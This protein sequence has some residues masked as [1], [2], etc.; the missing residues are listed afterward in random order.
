V[1]RGN[2]QLPYIIAAVGGGVLFISLFL[3]WVSGPSLPAGAAG[4]LGL[5]KTGWELFSAVDVFL[6]ILG[7][8]TIAYCVL[9]V[10]GIEQWPWLRAF[11]RWG[12]LVGLVIV[13][14]YVVDQ[15]NAPTVSSFSSDLG[16]GVYVA[17]VASLAIFL[18]GLLLVRPDLARRLE[19]ATEGRERARPDATSAQP[20]GT[21]AATATPR[22][23]AP[24]A[25]AVP[26]ARPQAPAAPPSPAAPTRE[27]PPATPAAAPQPAAAPAPAAAPPEPPAAHPGPPAGWYPDPQGLARLRYW[28]GTA[29]TDHTS[30]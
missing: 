30:A 22:A 18:G 5:S 4:R 6:A 17:L 19:A 3:E 25:P 2:R 8:A 9:W 12:G 14:N 7:I 16:V 26:A 24:Q 11:V 28:D 10:L 1:N 15:D 21:P 23:A 29:W 13:L 27:A 20:A